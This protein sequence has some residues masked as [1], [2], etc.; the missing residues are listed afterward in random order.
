[1][2]RPTFGWVRIEALTGLGRYFSF[3]DPSSAAI[4]V[5]L[6]AAVA[7]VIAVT[8]NAAVAT[9]IAAYTAVF[10]AALNITMSSQHSQFSVTNHSSLFGL[11]IGLAEYRSNLDAAQAFY[12]VRKDLERNID[13]LQTLEP[14]TWGK[15]RS[16]D[17]DGLHVVLIGGDDIPTGRVAVHAD[18]GR[19]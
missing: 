6:N 8:L 3:V 12:Q 11:D 14:R 15:R 7:A 10:S 4:I 16:V 9:V 13:L 5:P 2:K 1:M 17:G 19:P 18:C